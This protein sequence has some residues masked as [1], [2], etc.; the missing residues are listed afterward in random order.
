MARTAMTKLTKIWEDRN[1]SKINKMRLVKSLVFSIFLYGA[2]TWTIRK[3]EKNKIDAFEMWCWR[4]MLRISWTEHRTNISI[5]E[6][7]NVSQR[8]SSVCL[9]R[10]LQFFGHIIRRPNGSLERLI[11][12]GDIEGVRSRGRCPFRW[13]DPIKNITGS[14]YTTLREAEDRGKWKT[15]IQRT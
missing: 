3:A 13:S 6:E 8:L 15:V 11:V 7:L 1:I 9:Q 2:E 4:R 5:L 14:F 12:T 10:T